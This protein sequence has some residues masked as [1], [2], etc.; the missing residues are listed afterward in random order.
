M[1]IAH[2]GLMI[3]FNCN[4]K[5]FCIVHN[6]DTVCPECDGKGEHFDKEHPSVLKEEPV[7]TKPD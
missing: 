1:L 4:G 5:G 7:S 6:T 3:C 2:N